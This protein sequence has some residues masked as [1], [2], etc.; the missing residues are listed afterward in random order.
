MSVIVRLPTLGD[1][2]DGAKLREAF[3]QIEFALRQLSDNVGG[4]IEFINPSPGTETPSVGSSTIVL[5]NSHPSPLGSVNP[6]NVAS[7]SRADHVHPLP[8]AA[9]VGADPAG[10]ADAAIDGHLAQADP[11]P[12]YALESNMFPFSPKSVGDVVIPEGYNM[13]VGRNGL[14]VGGE[15]AINGTLEVVDKE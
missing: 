11:H 1:D 9:Q 8:T 4:A 7:I 10:S 15:I 6:G 14:I 13:L 3:R 5:S 2:Y 12:Q